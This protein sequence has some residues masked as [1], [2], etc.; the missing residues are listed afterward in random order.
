M[1]CDN[2]GPKGRPRDV[3]GRPALPV[4]TTDPPPEP[5]S[6]QTPAEGTAIAHSPQ[7]RT[8]RKGICTCP[9]VH[10]THARTR[11]RDALKKEP[12]Q[13]RERAS[14]RLRPPSSGRLRPG[15]V[16]L[17]R[18]V[19][20]APEFSR[21]RHKAPTGIGTYRVS[22]KVI[23]THRNSPPNPPC[24]HQ[25]P[26]RAQIPNHPCGQGQQGKLQRYNTRNHRSRWMT[27]VL[28]DSPSATRCS[29]IVDVTRPSQS[30]CPKGAESLFRRLGR[31]P[32]VAVFRTF[33]R[34]E[35]HQ[36]PSAPDRVSAMT[37]HQ[38]A[39]HKAST[40]A[41]NS[42]GKRTPPRCFLP[43][44]VFV[45]SPRLLCLFPAARPPP[46]SAFPGP[47]VTVESGRLL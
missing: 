28:P 31:P 20:W 41:S 44:T 23:S 14:M 35:G 29:L 39:P 43:C 2:R 12:W 7:A 34:R 4:R 9:R 18:R 26:S 13:S 36:G 42:S 10:G 32:L 21:H 40:Q 37:K 47:C 24:A 46:Q 22:G 38:R 1:K 19:H 33:R 15:E 25:H 5:T 45:C 16:A 8:C 6:S 30:P 3:Q 11:H 27:V 17:A